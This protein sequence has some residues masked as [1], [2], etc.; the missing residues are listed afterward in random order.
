MTTYNSLTHFILD[1]PRYM[2]PY[3][4]TNLWFLI[5]YQ[6]DNELTDYIPKIEE[7]YGNISNLDQNK[8]N[9]D[10]K[11]ILNDLSEYEDLKVLRNGKIIYND[12]TPDGMIS[13]SNCGNV[14]DGN[15]QCICYLDDYR[16]DPTF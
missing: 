8:I 4:Y 9:Q 12:N 16:W 1:A 14:W 7:S 10:L 15:A 6:N 3:E 13:C 2:I 5:H 11:C